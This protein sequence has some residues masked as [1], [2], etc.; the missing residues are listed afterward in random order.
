MKHH[1]LYLLVLIMA[2][3]QPKSVDNSTTA[4]QS[5]SQKTIEKEEV[6]IVDTTQFIPRV[7]QEEI[8]KAKEKD[9]RRKVEPVTPRQEKNKPEDKVKIGSD[10][11]VNEVE[12][13]VIVH[14]EQQVPPA[15]PVV[16]ADHSIWD[17]LLSQYVTSTGRV[18]YSGL[19]KKLD[20]LD[21]YLDNLQ[22]YPPNETDSP[23][24]TMA[25]WINAYN[26]FT[27]KLILDN[28]PVSSIM[29]LDNGKV[30]DRKWVQL[31]GRT[32]SLNDIEH[33]ILRKTFKD[34]RIHFAVNCAAASCPPLYNRAWTA[35]NLESALDQ[36]TRKFINNSQYNQISETNLQLSKIFEWYASDFG[37][38]VPYINKY[39]SI[40]VA[41]NALVN[42]V[43][44][45]WSL[46][47][48]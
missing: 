23:N 13:E 36:Q 18:D 45:D 7:N 32:L 40:N 9:A 39:S 43:E 37:E 47:G 22:Q 34:A 14:K 41:K 26:A 2:C 28:L 29:K 11:E 19:R 16:E 12:E 38:I 33:K 8:Q 15:P 24:A 48:N 25:Y 46:N 27:V 21:Q 5:A 31:D 44:Y 3:T 4:D 10:E 20:L 17:G 42:F 1:M 30:W 35:S 6:K